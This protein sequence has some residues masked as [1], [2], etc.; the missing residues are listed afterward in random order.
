MTAIALAGAA[1][2]VGEKLYSFVQQERA[3]LQQTGEWTDEQEAG[4]DKLTKD[5]ANSAYWQVR[6]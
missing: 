3:R 2:S 6:A 5:R 1:I 4:F